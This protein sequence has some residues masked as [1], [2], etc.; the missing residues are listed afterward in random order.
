MIG[1]VPMPVQSF[2]WSVNRIGDR[3]APCGEPV[4]IERED[5]STASW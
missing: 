3:T 2:V 1:V 5:E 4:Q